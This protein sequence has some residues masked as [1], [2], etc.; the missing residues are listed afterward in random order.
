MDGVGRAVLR[1]KDL[2]DALGVAKS[3][4]SDWIVEFQAFIPIVK[5]GAVVYYKPE[6]VDVLRVIQKMREQG[7]AKPDIFAQLRAEGFP[8]TVEEAEAEISQALSRIDGRKALVEV[9]AQVGSAL[10]QLAS[11]ETLIERVE[12]RQ[13]GQDGRVT[14]LEQTV[15]KLREQVE[16]LQ[17]QLATT[18]K[19]SWWPFGR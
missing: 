18:K 4:L 7:R 11:Q 8:I 19:R 12:R 15:N 3:T 1:K 5:E 6:A 10:G 13:D 9:M 2:I 14:E 17:E 16:Q